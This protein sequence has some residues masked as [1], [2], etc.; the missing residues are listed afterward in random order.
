MSIPAFGEFAGPAASFAKGLERIG[1]FKIMVKGKRQK[2]EPARG[3]ARN[4]C[5]LLM[6]L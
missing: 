1:E 3:G 4:Q 5:S 2:G 6:V